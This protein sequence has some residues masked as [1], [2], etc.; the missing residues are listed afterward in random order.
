MQKKKEK[1]G[2]GKGAPRR[3]LRQKVHVLARMRKRIK[4]AAVIK[5]G[6]GTG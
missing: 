5:S 6:V 1:K 2:K 3:K 4:E